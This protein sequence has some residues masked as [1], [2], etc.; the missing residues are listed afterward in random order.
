MTTTHR[1]STTN[2]IAQLLAAILV[3]VVLVTFFVLLLPVA[4]ALVGVLALL[5]IGA[6]IKIAIDRK[7]TARRDKHVPRRDREGRRN[8][9][10]INR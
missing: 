10:V 3:V 5:V 8:V 4:L 1:M 9:R 7:L 6:Q 2:P